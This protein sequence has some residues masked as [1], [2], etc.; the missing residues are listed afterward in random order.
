M[1]IERGCNTSIL[2][3]ALNYNAKVCP[4]NGDGLIDLS[5][6][7]GLIDDQTV[8]ISVMY[9]N[10]EIGTIE[11]LLK[12][13][14]IIKEVK[15][16]RLKRGIAT[17]LYL[18]SDACQAPNY[19]SLSAPKLGLDLMTLNG[20][21][22]YGP[23]QSAILYVKSNLQIKPLI[24]G[25]GQ[26]FGLRSGTEDTASII[27]FAKALA[28]AQ[29]DSKEE[30]KRLSQLRDFFIKEVL[31]ISPQISLNGSLK[32]RLAN[33]IN[34]LIKNVDNETL[35]MK[36]DNCGVMIA[37]GSACNASSDVPSHVLKAIGLSGQDVRSSF[38]ITL[39]RFT[40][41]E[42]LKNTLGYFQQNLT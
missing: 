35:I 3:P 13:A 5:Q 37:S 17:P 29:R 16:N 4:V 6:L 28:I 10:N 1:Q 40:T 26:E 21:K 39:G 31:K 24:E 33:N 30:S 22:I 41:K 42:D 36:L 9:A 23:K 18:H 15:T 12:V 38:R 34:I 32:N 27:G 20:C 25:G 14:E 7:L 8:L 2:R 19:L 11:P